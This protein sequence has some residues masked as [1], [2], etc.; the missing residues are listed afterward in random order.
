MRV[1]Q[2]ADIATITAASLGVR[3]GNVRDLLKPALRRASY[4]L[5]PCSASDL[6]RFVAEPLSPLGDLREETEAEL[7]D[8]IAYGDI[9]EMRRI[10]GDPWDTPNVVLRPAP[11]AFVMRSKTQAFILGVGGDYPSPLPA[12]LSASLDYAGPVRILDCPD[13]EDFAGHLRE[14]GLT[15]L[16]EQAWL[17]IPPVTSAAD[18]VADWRKRLN[19]APSNTSAVPDLEVIDPTCPPSFY[20]GR[21]RAPRQ[22]EAGLF[23]ARRPQVFGGKLWCV[24]ELDAG[25]PTRLL[26]LHPSDVFIRPCDQAWRL[27]AALDAVQETPQQVV[28]TED[29]ASTHLSF[30]GPLPSFAERKL[31]LVATKSRAP[32]CL[33]RFSSS[34]GSLQEEIAFLQSILWMQPIRDGGKR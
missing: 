11:P 1:I 19:A 18:H 22:A 28:I 16:G 33:F 6:I 29:A 32:Q 23:V 7:Q 15:Q 9:F 4:L 30:G 25:Q 27:Q 21:W 24:V 3:G 34:T 17:R 20:A 5:A 26:D 31:A 10:D 14:F 12:E 13:D 8:L 2:P